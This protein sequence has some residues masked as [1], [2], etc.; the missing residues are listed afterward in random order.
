MPPKAIDYAKALTPNQMK[1]L[2]LGILCMETP[3][4]VDFEKLAAMT[5]YQAN[6][7][8]SSFNSA[9]RKIKETH[10]A[11]ALDASPD[12]ATNAAADDNEGSAAPPSAGKKAKP[13]A[14]ATSG[15][16]RKRQKKVDAEEGSDVEALEPAPDSE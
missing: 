3:L 14:K 6:S 16:K 2:L 7:A 13:R 5:G 12:P 11:G 10:E 8:R 1:F 4:K 9:L 15:S